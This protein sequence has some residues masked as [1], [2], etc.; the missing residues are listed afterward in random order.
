[1]MSEYDLYGGMPP[2]VEDSDTSCAAAKSVE[3]N[4]TAL[5]GKI[6][7]TLL[8]HPEGLTC[9]EVEA[10]TGLRHQ[11]ASARI[12]ELY[13][14][15]Q[16]RDSGYRR[17]TDTRRSAVVWCTSS[18]PPEAQ[19]PH[20]SLKDQ[21]NELRKALEDLLMMHGHCG[22]CSVYDDASGRFVVKPDTCCCSP[23]VKRAWAAL[24]ETAEEKAAWLGPRRKFDPSEQGR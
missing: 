17:M 6:Y 16:I 15:G 1:M 5:R 14:K 10:M 19:G 7:R 2:H 22:S 21:A 18:N 13:L 23:E 3:N 12:R 11:T 24:A 20:Q 4:A 9:H 8:Q